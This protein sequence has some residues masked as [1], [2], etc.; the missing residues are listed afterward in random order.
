MGSQERKFVLLMGVMICHTYRKIWQ[1][2]ILTLNYFLVA[3]SL[4]IS[5]LVHSLFDLLILL[6]CLFTAMCFPTLM[7]FLCFT[8]GVQNGTNSWRHGILSGPR[9][10]QVLM[11]RKGCLV[12]VKFVC[13]AHTFV[14]TLWQVLSVCQYIF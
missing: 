14:I 6:I 8:G 11:S 1:A 3:H 4:K 10:Q 7:I 12:H 2:N 9:R 13:S 5:T